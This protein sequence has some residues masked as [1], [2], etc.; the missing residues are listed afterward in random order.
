MI[1]V[2]LILPYPAL[3]AGMRALLAADP[4]ITVI[5]NAAEAQDAGDDIAADVHIVTSAAFVRHPDPV[6]G[7]DSTEGVILLGAENLDMRLMWARSTP[8]G[9][10]PLEVSSEELCAAVR[11]VAAGLVVGAR[12]LLTN[13]DASEVV[14]GP[15]T[16]REVEILGM[17]SRGLANKQIAVQLG[18]SEHT[19]KFHVSSIYARLSVANR[20]QAVREGLRNGWITL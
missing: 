9:V 17:L 6:A 1:R 11:A 18:I 20:T 5:D 15:L 8:W 16:E 2:R 3:E 19:V 7:R 12:P 14:R 13:P 4:G 10:L